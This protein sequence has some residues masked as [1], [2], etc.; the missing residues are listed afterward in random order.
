MGRIVLWVLAG[1]LVLGAA[2]WF[3]GP[4][5]PVD[6]T[7]AFKADD[8]GTDLDAYL[9]SKE[10]QVANLKS[11]AEKQIVWHGTAGT[12]TATAIVYI[13]GFSATLEEIRP[14]PD[15]VAQALGAN[16]YY[17]RLAGHGRDGAAMAEAR[18]NDWFNDT[19]EALA[20]GR[21][22]GDK[23][24]IVS[25]STGGTLSAWAELKPD[26]MQNVIGHVMVSPNFT[27]QADSAEI[28]T[29]PFGRTLVP[30]IAG[31]ER[32]FEPSNPDHGK[33]WTTQYPTVALIPMQAVVAHT[34]ALPFENAARPALFVYHPED[35]V[36]KSDVSKAIAARWGKTG[37]G[38]ATVHEVTQAEDP[39]DH[40]IGGRILSPANSEP[41]AAKIIEWAKAL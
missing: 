18:V 30:L 8:L 23:V 35:K 20:I 34:R 39:F 11:G 37:G 12:K 26:L 2:A 3:L 13:H 15:L 36:V 40:V 22:I 4:R 10:A 32:S 6:E 7:L 9:S 19:A 16:I 41:L 29:M 31:A 5:E 24:L 14:V 33:W 28:L 27:V 38:T 17:A 21:A 1:L 25:T